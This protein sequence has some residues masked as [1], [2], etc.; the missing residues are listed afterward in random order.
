M[1][2]LP[3]VAQTSYRGSK[4]IVAQVKRAD[5][6]CGRAKEP[7][8][9]EVEPRRRRLPPQARQNSR[10]V[11]ERICVGVDRE[12]ARIQRIGVSQS[13]RRVDQGASRGAARIDPPRA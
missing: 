5:D 12:H 11:A 2:E 9:V 6:Q 3:L 4:E 1:P 10:G 13:T 8:S 7:R